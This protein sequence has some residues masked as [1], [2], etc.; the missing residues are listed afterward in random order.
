MATNGNNNS[1]LRRLAGAVKSR[2]RFEE[3]FDRVRKS[4]DHGNALPFKILALLD[5]ND[6][7]QPFLKALQVAHEHRF[8]ADLVDLLMDAGVIDIGALGVAPAAPLTVTPKLQALTRPELGF[9]NIALEIS[10]KLEATRRLCCIHILNTARTDIE[11]SGTGFLVGPQLVL[12]SGHL[13]ERLLDADGMS[14]TGSHARIRITFDHIN[15][16]GT[17]T[18]IAVR[19]HE[20]L[21][22][23]SQP[24]PS[25]LSKVSPDWDKLPDDGFDEFLDY[26]LIRLSRPVGYE[27]GFY[28]LDAKRL[29]NVADHGHVGSAIALFQHPDGR[30]LSSSV[31]QVLRLCPARAKSRVLHNANSLPGS[32]GGLLVDNEFKPVG[33]HQ[34]SYVDAQDKPLYNGA[35]PTAR[36]ASLDLGLSQV[37]GLDPVWNLTTTGE[38]VIGREEFQRSIMDALAGVARILTVAGTAGMGRS[39]STKIL[40]EILGISEHLVVELSASVLPINARETAQRLLVEIAGQP[41]V[42]PLPSTDQAESAQAAWVTQELVPAFNSAFA[43]ISGSR[44]VWLVLDDLDRHPIANTSTRLFLE[45]L[46]SGMNALP[47]LRIVL[48]GFQ[49]AVPGAVAQQVRSENLR[50]FTD[51]ELVEYVSR[52]ATSSGFVRT[53]DASLSIARGLLQDVEI[54]PDRGRQ[55]GLAQQ[56]AIKARRH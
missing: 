10:G 39:F 43:E 27:R 47:N 19:E 18:V 28:S 22:G 35:I 37:L 9:T 2:E 25:E 51:E 54:L 24:H 48:I 7:P 29:P 1:D 49:G 53:H 8:L 50:E 41:N 11:A 34:C 38:P 21:A 6:P 36:I 16:Q 4:A 32:S 20:W 5:S 13:V 40:R 45:S 42:A 31:G 17:G 44:T 26:A 55:A 14:T 12:T 33:L 30:P 3:I 56:A 23:H 52:V 46:Y 15:G